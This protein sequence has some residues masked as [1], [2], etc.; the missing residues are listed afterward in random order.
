MGWLRI[1]RPGSVIGRQQHYLCDK[2]A[3]MHQAGA[4]SRRSGPN[5]AGPAGNDW[6]EGAEAVERL[7]EQTRRRVRVAL[8]RLKAGEDGRPPSPAGSG[9]PAARELAAHVMSAT[10]GRARARARLV[11]A[12][13]FAAAAA[14]DA[15]GTPAAGAADPRHAAAEG[16]R[17]LP[18]PKPTGPTQPP[19]LL[20]CPCCRRHRCHTPV[21]G[22]GR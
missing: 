14:S 16:G 22:R 13:C 7:V 10:N 21:E 18:Q 17:R 15:P 6:A 1:M 4:E 8:L 19:R 11:A 12:A 2:E 9:S 5:A 20:P 3:I